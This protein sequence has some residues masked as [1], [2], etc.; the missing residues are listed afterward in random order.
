MVRLC[1]SGTEISIT[2]LLEVDGDSCFLSVKDVGSLRN[3]MRQD[4]TNGYDV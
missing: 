2:A 1:R 3:N 4:Q